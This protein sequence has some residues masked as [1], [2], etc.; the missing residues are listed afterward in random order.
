M[1]MKNAKPRRKE[2]WVYFLLSVRRDGSEKIYV[3]ST[4]RDV[5]TRVGEHFRK[6]HKNAWTAK[7]KKNKLLG[8]IWSKD[9]LKEERRIK[10]LSSKEKRDI[11]KQGARQYKEKEKI[12]K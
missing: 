8:A 9:R 12:N 2:G 5:Y 6:K 4:S 7:A 1:L 3:G 10:K 11:A